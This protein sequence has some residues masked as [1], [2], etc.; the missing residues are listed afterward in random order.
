MRISTSIYHGMSIGNAS[1]AESAAMMRAAG[2][3]GAD[4]ELTEFQTEPAK[5]L[6]VEWKQHVL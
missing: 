1:A 2:F 5:F 3:Q 6:S 4:L